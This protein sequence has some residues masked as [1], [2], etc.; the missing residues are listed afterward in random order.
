MVSIKEL[1]DG[2]ERLVFGSDS[3]TSETAAVDV[4]VDD[5]SLEGKFDNLGLGIKEKV[6][7]FQRPHDDE[8]HNQNNHPVRPGEA[9]CAHF[10]RTGSCRYGLKCRYNH[11]TGKKK[12]QVGNGK[13]KETE[14][15]KERQ[16]QLNRGFERKQSQSW[17]DSAIEEKEEAEV[18]GSL[19][20]PVRPG[21]PDCGHY[22][23]TGA[24]RYGLNCRYNHPSR[25]KRQVHSS[26]VSH[27]PDQ[28]KEGYEETPGQVE[29]KYYL[30]PGG[31]K[32]GTT[33]RFQHIQEKPA[34]AST[35]DLNF[36]GLP[37]RPGETECPH[38]M[39][40]GSCKFA[41]N[42]RFHHPNPTDVGVRDPHLRYQ[43]CRPSPVPSSVL[44]QPG[45]PSWS[46]A[47]TSNE[48][49]VSYMDAVPSYAPLLSAPQGV[50]PSME[51]NG[52]LPPQQNSMYPPAVNMGPHVPLVLN[53]PSKK[54]GGFAHYQQQMPIDEYPE[55]PGEKECEYF[56]KNGD[57]KFKSY[58]KFDHPKNRAS[59]CV[60]SPMGLPLRP[61]EIACSYYS[62]YGICKFGPACK[63]DHPPNS[64]SSISGGVRM[65]SHGNIKQGLIQQAV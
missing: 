47:R 16:W 63:Y 30:R 58:C 25:S 3:S 10:V 45:V 50:R 40:N 20:H 62:R 17:G 64:G 42:C 43:N 60:L 32:Y 56:M 15:F 52:Y 1:E 12:A 59:K 55:R 61:E 14:G 27:E 41:L 4:S 19:H 29:C 2:D 9:D 31:C 37:V 51:W 46:M 35:L 57:C 23:R 11:P 5:S 38:Y 39:R 34:V 13:D 7:S 8:N 18:N 36:L 26:S 53:G 49:M 44:S 65:G 21:E 28:E 33:C 6:S 22:L 48:T 54:T 24:C